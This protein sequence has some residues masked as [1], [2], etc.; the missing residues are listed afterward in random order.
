MFFHEVARSTGDLIASWMAVG[1]THGVMNT[2]NMSI[3]GLTIDYGSG[4]EGGRRA[5][6]REKRNGPGGGKKEG[7]EERRE[8]EGRL[9]GGE[10]GSGWGRREE[11]GRVKEKEGRQKGGGREGEG[12]REGSKQGCKKEGKRR[13]QSGKL[14]GSKEEGPKNL[15]FFRT[16]WISRLLSSGICSQWFR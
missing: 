13:G 4:V 6:G 5:K 9:K 7:R 11:E 8:L 15:I 2:D 1:F 14:R 12:R 3:L 10:D 16:L